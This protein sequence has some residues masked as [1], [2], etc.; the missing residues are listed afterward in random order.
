MVNRIKFKLFKELRTH[1]E[2]YY[3]WTQFI[4]LKLHQAGLMEK[5]DSYVNWDPV[6]KTVLANEQ[7]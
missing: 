2:N 6:D 3:K 4:I 7:G 5:R 1:D